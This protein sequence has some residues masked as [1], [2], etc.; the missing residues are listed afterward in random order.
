MA[1]QDDSLREI[2]R[3][4]RAGVDEQIAAVR[5]EAATARSDAGVGLDIAASVEERLQALE[6]KADKTRMLVEIDREIGVLF[7]G[8]LVFI[9]ASSDQDERQRQADNSDRYLREWRV[10]RKAI[11]D[12]PI[13]AARGTYLDALRF[14]DGEY[15]KFGIT[16]MT[17][18]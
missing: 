17:R 16:D 4:A 11:R 10:F 3:L 8:S 15:G 14:I 6:E 9:V 18:D 13:G 7:T 2:I 5:E 12:E 1:Q